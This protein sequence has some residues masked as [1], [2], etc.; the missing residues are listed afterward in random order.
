[1]IK[2]CSAPISWKNKET[3]ELNAMAHATSEILWPH[4]LFAS[5]QVPC[6]KSTLLHCDNQT[7]L[8]FAA[9]PIPRKN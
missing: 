5:L 1:M 9:N 8:H 2:P 6:T 3:S 7:A 4:N